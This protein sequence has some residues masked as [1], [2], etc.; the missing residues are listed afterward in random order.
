[1]SVFIVSDYHIETMETLSIGSSPYD[2]ECVMVESG[3]NYLPAM[4]TEAERFIAMLQKRFANFSRIRF[5][6]Q[7]NNHDFGTY[8]DVAVRFDDNDEQA[9]N[10]AYFAESHIP[11]TW[12]DDHVFPAIESCMEQLKT[13]WAA[14]CNFKEPNGSSCLFC[15]PHRDNCTHYY[16]CPLMKN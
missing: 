5:F 7:R 1:M 3:R 6:V 14:K 16:S 10:E 4:R 15:P 12:S 2:E 8:L 13:E 9:G 11:G